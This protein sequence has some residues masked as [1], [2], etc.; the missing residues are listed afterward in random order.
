MGRQL[1]IE[2]PNAFY[3]VTARGNER[4]DVFKSDQDRQKFPEYLESAVVRYSAVIHLWCLM[5]N[6]YHLLVETPAGNLSAA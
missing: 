2:Y 6:H 5:R 4:K 1:R 3:H